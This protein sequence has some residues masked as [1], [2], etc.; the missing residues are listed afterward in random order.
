MTRSATLE[1]SSFCRR[2]QIWRLVTNLPSRPASGEVFTQKFMVS[3][4]SS[5]F[6]MGSG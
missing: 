5:I 3:V 6:S 1:R 4:G 2:S